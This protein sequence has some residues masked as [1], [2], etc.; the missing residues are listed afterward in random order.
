MSD[1]VIYMVFSVMESY[2][3]F[4][5][6]FKIFKIDVY[7]KEMLFAGF[8]LGC[9][10]YVIRVDY[11][12]VEIDII[13]QYLLMFCFFWLLFRVHFFYAAILTGMTYQAYTFI[14]TFYIFILNKIGLFS[15]IAFYGRIIDSYV[16]QIL[17]ALTTILISIY[18]G[19]KRKGF[20]FIPDKPNGKINTSTREKLLFIL[21]LPT[22]AIVISIMYLFNSKFFYLIPLIYGVL[23]FCYIYLSYTKD[24]GGNEYPQ[25]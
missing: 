13:V 2:T 20:D 9:F 21:N 6:A 5:L 17:S 3:M 1:F 18:I 12:M 19:K 15:S 23:L 7:P 10:S 14:Q 8:L 11:Q 24:R 25:P 16:L 22:V 4:L